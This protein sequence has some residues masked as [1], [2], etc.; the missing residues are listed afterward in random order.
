MNI[1]SGLSCAFSRA[2]TLVSGQDGIALLMVLVVITILTT[3][4]V[5][6][7]D[8]TQ[9]HLRVT[10]YYKNRLQAYWAAQSGLQAAA[11]L[12]R[13][14]PGAGNPAGANSLWNCESVEYRE[15]VTPILANIFCESSIIEGGLLLADT[16][17][18]ETETT[19]S[20]CP[21]AVP[22]MDENRKLSLAGLLTDK[23]RTD[24]ET[25]DRL[26]T[27]LQTLLNERDLAPAGEQQAS[28]SLDFD[29]A[30]KISEGKADELAGYLVDW[31]DT[32][33]NIP[34][35]VL[36][37]DSAEGSCPVDGLPYEAKN[38]LLDSIDEIGLVCGFRQMARPTIERLTRNLTA[39]KL[40]TNINTA[41]YAVLVAFTEDEGAAN[42]I[43]RELHG[44]AEQQAITM[45]ENAAACRELLQ[46][47]PQVDQTLCSIGNERSFG[48]TSDH[49]RIGIYGVVFDT[50][51]GT[52]TARTR[53][54][55][56]LKR[57]QDKKLN[58]L[59]Y[60]ED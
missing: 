38:G 50:E 13:M 46:D 48:L 53:L 16:N 31:I 22:I 27:L 1:L 25:F 39:Y 17:S 15:I 34:D 11:G 9:K 12:L 42:D 45:L 23:N 58:L 8:T 6:F 60:R 47:Y 51:T 40:Q 59:Y 49:F 28:G 29:Q 2:R 54:Q 33:D 52:V 55:M 57:G 4:V 14:D 18:A 30:T 43:Y 24:G 19:L 26:S 32:Q 41:T 7:T 44:T 3:L 56:D 35:P 20:R 5:S 21:A 37:P 10:Q 36:N